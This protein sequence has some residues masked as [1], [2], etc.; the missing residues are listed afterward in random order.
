MNNVIGNQIIFVSNIMRY[1]KITRVNRIY[2][3]MR[4]HNKNN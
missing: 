3:K 4:Q 1:N 2:L